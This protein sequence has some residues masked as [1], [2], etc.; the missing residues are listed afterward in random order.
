MPPGAEHLPIF[1]VSDTETDPVEHAPSSSIENTLP[2]GLVPPGAEHLPILSVA[3]TEPNPVE[4]A[5]SSCIENPQ[6]FTVENSSSHPPDELPLSVAK[7]P[8]SPGIK[9]LPRDGENTSDHGLKSGTPPAPHSQLLSSSE[10]PT[11][12][13]NNH[14][15]SAD[16]PKL[17]L[18]FPLSTDIR[19]SHPR[20]RSRG[21]TPNSVEEF[22]QASANI[23][24][25]RQP[26]LSQSRS[27]SILSTSRISCI[28][29]YDEL[30][31]PG[32]HD[33]PLL[34]STAQ[35][36]DDDGIQCDKCRRWS[37]MYCIRTQWGIPE[38]F[39]EFWMCQLCLKLGNEEEALWA[40]D[41][42]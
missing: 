25:S 33:L 36:D 24:S 22:F 6:P 32:G 3:D 10:P 27:P 12:Q 20:S 1:S 8:I 19:T 42:K 40:H 21:S 38:N 18:P 5:P 16:D 41:A 35:S 23:T 34:P 4:H 9:P 13:A 29:C 14:Q 26:P 39:N 17:P 7:K 11:S 37:H 15:K 31:R 28:G 2:S 30:G